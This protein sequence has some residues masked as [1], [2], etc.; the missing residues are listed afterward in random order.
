M[1]SRARARFPLMNWRAE[2]VFWTPAGSCTPPSQERGDA[3]PG[4][5]RGVDDAARAG[6]APHR[7][8]RTS[9]RNRGDEG[10]RQSEYAPALPADDALPGVAGGPFERVRHGRAPRRAHGREQARAEDRRER[11]RGAHRD[12]RRLAGDAVPWGGLPQGAG[13]TGTSRAGRQRQA[14]AA[15]DAAASP[16]GAAA[17]RAAQRG[18]RAQ[19]DDHHDASGR[20]VAPMPR[21]STPR[22]TGGVGSSGAIDHHTDELL[23]WHVAARRPVG[24]RW[25]RSARARGTPSAASARMARGSRSAATGGRSTSPTPGST[26]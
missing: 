1:P 11:R 16:P 15:A 19:W 8:S 10:H 18:S 3:R 4:E 2:R 14:G 23:G 5:D 7:G 20:D 12:P 22:P 9:G 21:G 6:R 26:R 17:A 25:S 24:R 13:A